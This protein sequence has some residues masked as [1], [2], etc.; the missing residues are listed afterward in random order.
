MI[1]PGNQLGGGGKK[2]SLALV[3]KR[4]AQASRRY[5]SEQKVNEG[6]I[7]TNFPATG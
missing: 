2:L 4:P 7:L 6:A 5:V 3:A 1:A